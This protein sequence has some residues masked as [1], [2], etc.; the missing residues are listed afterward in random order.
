M[1]Q[2]ER[3]EISIKALEDKIANQTLIIERQIGYTQKLT[4]R[5]EVAMMLLSTLTRAFAFFSTILV[6]IRVLIQW[7][8]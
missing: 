2:H 6:A 5:Y 1:N 3:L 4:E 7:R 8:N